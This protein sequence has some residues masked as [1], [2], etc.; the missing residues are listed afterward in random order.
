MFNSIYKF[1]APTSSTAD[2]P[3]QQDLGRRLP[4]RGPARGDVRHRA[5]HG[6]A[7]RR[8]RG[9]PARDPREELDHPR[10]VPVHHRGGDDLRLGQLRGGHGQGRA[11]CSA[12]TSCAPSSS[13]AAT[14]GT[15][16]SSASASRRSP[17]C[18]ASPR[19]ASSGSLSYGAGGWESATIRM[20]PTGKVE[21]VT[22]TS[23]HGQGHETAWS[24]IVADRLGVPFEDVEV[25]HGDTQIAPKGLDSY[26]SRSLVV[27][28]EALVLAADKVIENAKPI[29]A[30]LLEADIDDLEFTAGHYHVKGTDK[31]VSLADIALATFAAHNLPDGMDAEHRRQRDLRPGELLVPARHPPVRDGGRHRDGRDEDAQ[32]RLRRRHR[33]HHQPDHRR[34]PGPRRPRPGHRPGAVGGRGVRREGHPRHGV[35]RRLHAA[36]GRRHDQLRH[37]P[38]DVAVDDEHAGHQGGRRGGQHRLDPRRGQRHRRRR[39]ATSGSTTS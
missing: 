21:V 25:L 1:P 36:H 5:A 34:G 14:A 2:R 30:H 23:P 20:L 38:H 39:A 24:Q 7:R 13:A 10:G 18:A 6:R 31:G 26:G 33:H 9:R 12:T 19:R 29:A 32:V 22:G 28:G 16:S 37:R 17:R 3:H 11:S 35:V 27:G 15:R 4:G 8:G